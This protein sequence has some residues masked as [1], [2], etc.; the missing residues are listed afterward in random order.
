MN[1]LRTTYSQHIYQPLQIILQIKVPFAYLDGSHVGVLGDVLVLVE[2]ILGSLSF[3]KV[4][5]QF[6]EK[7]HD[8][9]ERGDRTAARPL[10]GDM[11]VEDIE[12]G[13]SLAH[14]NKFLS[15]L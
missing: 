14:G 6:N 9:F 7:E 5:T 15:P 10:R 8:R 1:F 11:F 4:D 3:A 13:G 12:G 2:T